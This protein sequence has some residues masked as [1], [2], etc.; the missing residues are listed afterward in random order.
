MKRVGAKSLGEYA[1]VKLIMRRGQHIRQEL[2]RRLIRVE[3]FACFCVTAVYWPAVVK[4]NL[5]VLPHGE[6][7]DY[8]PD[9]GGRGNRESF[10][11][12]LKRRLV[13]FNG[14]YL[15]KMFYAGC[16][17][18]AFPVGFPGF[19]SYGVVILGIQF[20]AVHSPDWQNSANVL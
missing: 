17:E 18:K 20:A 8:I 2:I 9:R 19:S 3:Q 10:L 14:C 13:G 12:S 16:K 7:G 1:D 6:T 4:A 15:D 5:V 11:Y